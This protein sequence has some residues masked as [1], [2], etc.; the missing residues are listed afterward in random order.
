M[1][2][3]A[4]SSTATSTTAAA[5]IVPAVDAEERARRARVPLEMRRGL[6][7]KMFA[8]YSRR[9]YGAMLEPGMAMSHNTR[10]LLADSLLELQI[11]RFTALDPMLRTLATTAVAVQIECSWCLDFGY[12]EAHHRGMDLAK[13]SAVPRWQRSGIFTPTERR[14]LEYADA[15]TA[16]PPAVTDELAAQLRTELGDAAF[17]E[18]TM[19]VAVENLR[20]RFNAALGLASQGFSEACRL[21]AR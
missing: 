5:G 10:V 13:I 4:A 19:M 14:V 15:A 21:P 18:L 8:W 11:G 12:L 3:T 7:G 16:T 2:S 17:V 6:L 9:N 20:S 1:S